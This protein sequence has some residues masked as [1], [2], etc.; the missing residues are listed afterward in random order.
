MAHLLCFNRHGKNHCIKIQYAG[1]LTVICYSSLKGVKFY[2]DFFNFLV[3]RNAH[4]YI[5][6]DHVYLHFKGYFF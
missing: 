3:D 4:Q 2:E 5:H 1:Q 6:Y